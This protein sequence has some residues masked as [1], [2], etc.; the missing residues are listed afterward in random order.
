MATPRPLQAGH[1]AL[2]ESAFA[3]DVR[4]G[5]S[6]RPKRIPS[7]YFYDVEGSQ[8]FERI[9][10]QP[11][12][13]L[14]RT[15]LSILQ[16]HA[17]ELAAAIGP[18]ALLV[19]YGSGTA[20]KTG[21]LLE[22]LIDPAGYVPIEISASALESSTR[23]LAAHFPQLEILP[24]RGDFT[25]ARRLPVP[26]RHQRRSVVFFPGST[27]GNFAQSE[28]T[29]LL[30]HMRDDMGPGGAAV[31]GID[32]RKEPA[33]LEAAYN[34]A[35]GVTAR[36][37]LNLLTRMNRELGGDFRLDRFQHRAR[38]N[39]LAS[40]IE[41]HIVS[42]DEQAVHVAGR[43]FRFAVDEAM[44][45][46]YSHKYSLDDFAAMAQVVGLRV[47]RNFTDPADWFAVVLLERA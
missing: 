18:R 32:L 22:A 1:S 27:L 38:W 6:Q 29:A 12:Y 44:L 47:S 15:E 25:T 42:R 28:A 2:D 17:E 23:R 13:Y 7:K 14:T 33:L 35:A 3:V 21:L 8:L 41:T 4:A 36:F 9:C 37:T 45:V 10:A 46:E 40:R 43:S 31:I 26:H 19:E 30:R 5:L 11:E 34:D 20:R 24:L 16:A 39:P